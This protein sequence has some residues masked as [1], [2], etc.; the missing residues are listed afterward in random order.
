MVVERET[1]KGGGPDFPLLL[2]PRITAGW[3]RRQ[4]S[5]IPI[6]TDF[7]H[8]S[9]KMIGTDNETVVVG[10][11]MGKSLKSVSQRISGQNYF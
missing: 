5:R 1:K 10:N 3:L 9:E 8:G 2:P 11:G 7:K 4:G 6:S